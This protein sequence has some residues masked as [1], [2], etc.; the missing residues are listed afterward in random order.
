[1]SGPD[2]KERSE[3]AIMFLRGLVAQESC[4]EIFR[5]AARVELDVLESVLEHRKAQ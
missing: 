3:K 1:M 4:A 2:W 5:M